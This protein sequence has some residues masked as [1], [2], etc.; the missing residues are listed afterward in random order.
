MKLEPKKIDGELPRDQELDWLPTEPPI[1]ERPFADSTTELARGLDVVEMLADDPQSTL[2]DPSAIGACQPM[3]ADEQTAR[4]LGIQA[5]RVGS[6]PTASP[7][8]PGT[9]LDLC[10]IDGYRA[11]T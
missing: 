6:L 3:T 2:S 5:R 9:A 4:D 10:W 7:F 8:E 11:G 1:D